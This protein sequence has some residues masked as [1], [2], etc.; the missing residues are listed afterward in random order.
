MAE[1]PFLFF[2]K[3]SAAARDGLGRGR[4]RYKRPT[5]AKQKERLEKRFL[6]IADSFQ[7][8][9]ESA[10]GVEPEHVVVF[11]T[12]TQSVEGLARAIARVPG[13]EWMADID[14]GDVDPAEGFADA[15]TPSKRIPARLY[16]VFSNQRG[17]N[18]LLALWNDWIAEPQRPFERG[19]A[20]FKHLFANLSSIR[21]WDA[22]DRIA[23]TGILEQWREAVEVKGSQGTCRFEIELWFRGGETER[24]RL[25]GEVMAVLADAGGRPLDACVIPEIRYHAILA[26]APASYVESILGQLH[27]QR[28]TKLLLAEAVMFFRPHGQMRVG[29]PAAKPEPLE[30]AARLGNTPAPSGPAIVALLDGVPLAN[31]AALEGRLIIDDPDDHAS[32]YRAGQHG[33]G[34]AMAS[35]ILHGDLNAA[36]DVHQRPIYVRPLL[37]PADFGAGEVTP[38]DRL[39]ADLIHRA[40]R[41]IAEGEQKSPAIAPEVRIVNLSIGDSNRPFDRELSP[42]A[43]LID[44]LAWKYRLLFIISAGNRGTE[45]QLDT[46]GEEVASLSPQEL[47][48]KAIQSMRGDQYRR[49]LLSPAEAINAVTAGATQRDE[50]TVYPIGQRIDPFPPGI[51]GPSPI[52]TVSSGYRGS[53]KPE[54]V[55]PGGRQLLSAPLASSGGRVD[56]S[57]DVSAMAPGQLVA[58]PGVTP[59]ETRRVSYCRGTSNSAALATRCAAQAHAGLARARDGMSGIHL[60]D[61]HMAVVLKALLVH[62]ASW[63]GYTDLFDEAFP[64][65]PRKWQESFRVKRQ[66]VGYGEVDPARCVAAADERAT[67]VGW[68]E[69]SKDEGLR[70]EVPLP[71]SLS[72]TKD[73]R[74]LTV[75]L[76]WLSDCNHQ[77]QA[78]RRAHLYL[79]AQRE[80]IGTKNAGVDAKQAQRGTVE[81]RVFEGTEAKP[82]LDGHTLAVQVNCAAD[83]GGLS[84]RVPFG[85]AVSLEAAANSRIAVYDEVASRIRVRLG[86]TT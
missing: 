78:Y 14:L 54:I 21:R 24:N 33:H 22:R 34:T 63:E 1:R 16:A 48:V 85:L 75:T 60:D 66:F 5:P 39:L 69:I 70:F 59:M 9:Q 72:A 31:H 40:V 61:R 81:H 13:L 41:R 43:R 17:M 37:E 2:P 26:E 86:I 42:L 3:P 58:A 7:S 74:R 79:T 77:H 49:R 11:E 30:I 71:P 76:A 68:G 62:G 8:I 67:I 55:L 12:L 53:I 4:G 73:Y 52:T 50:C 82:F 47:A 57:I 46:K 20:P 19:L 45:L 15:D 65:P 38:P 27:D 44:W 83:A 25:T 23:N 6:E 10:H 56:L 18:R 80:V 28:H 29:L 51:A 32:R 64:M 35:L 36:G 84:G